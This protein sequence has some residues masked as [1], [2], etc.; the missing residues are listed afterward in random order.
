[1]ANYNEKIF[2][3]SSDYFDSL[4]HAIANA[5]QTIDLEVYIFCNDLLGKSV[6]DA[7]IKAAKRRVAIR[8]LVDGAGTPHWGNAMAKNLENA[9]VQTRIFHPFPWRFW[10]WSRSKV[11][12]SL[13][14]KLIYLLL[15]INSRNHR[16][17]CIIDK[18]II[19]TS[20]CNISKCHLDKQ[21]QGDG[22]R[23]AG[24]RLQTTNIHELQRA[25]NMAWNHESVKK[26]VKTTFKHIDT[27]PIIRLNNT[28][29]KRR[30][31]YRSLLY[32]ISKCKNRI[33]ITN[34]YFVPDNFLLRRL[35]K[36]A[37]NG[38]DVRIL[39][40]RYS[41]VMFMPWASTAFYQQLLRSNVRI[42]EY[43]PSMLH[44]K[45]LILDN[46]MMIGSSNWNYRSLMHDLDMDINIRQKK[47]KKILEQ[48]FFIDLQD[49]KEIKLDNWGWR[50][51]YQRI[52]GRLILYIKYYI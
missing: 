18:Q 32:R 49:S 22:W 42:F 43:L 36:A 52:L 29:Y 27:N 34:A 46:W 23:D 15:N 13:F 47:S 19:Y 9:G 26:Q 48:Q 41:D 28:W 16:K 11:K 20:S 1:M 45:T 2:F 5:K 14:L 31:L 33:W 7:L 6:I 12:A 51:L 24:M 25:F 50:P 39:L 17:T 40:P 44:A 3:N 4:L 37:K 35:K 21:N 38:V 10:Q 8:V 30:V